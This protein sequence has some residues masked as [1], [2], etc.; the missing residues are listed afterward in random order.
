[1][2]ERP[3]DLFS[4]AGSDVDHRARDGSVT[5]LPRNLVRVPSVKQRTDFSC[6]SAATLSLL[7]YWRWDVYARV[8]E[9]SLYLPLATT[10]ARG[11]EPQPIVSFLNTVGGI[12]AEYRHGDVTSS[13]LEK[14]VD[15]REPPIVDLQAWRD[16]DTPWRDIWD[17]GHYVIMVGYDDERLIFMDP[18]TM[19]PGAY[20]YLPRAEL[21]ERWHDLAGDHDER[22]ERMTIFARGCTDAWAPDEPASEGATRLG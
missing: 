16:H 11:T 9:A 7:R 20:A 10:R 4:H 8:D 13:D 6:G 17:A 18:S 15:A 5:P 22:I 14:A 2:E 19:T 12:A 1:M 3:L 21:A